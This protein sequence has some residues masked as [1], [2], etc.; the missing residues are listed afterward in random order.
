MT[1]LPGGIAAPQLWVANAGG[2]NR[3]G[4][5]CSD[6]EECGDFSGRTKPRFDPSKLK[7]QSLRNLWYL[8]RYWNY[9]IMPEFAIALFPPQLAL[10]LL[11]F[12]AQRFEQLFLLLTFHF[13][14][15]EILLLDFDHGPITL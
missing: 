8:L 5:W 10:Q 11:H 2:A 12:L 15:R 6:C 14:L 9:E 1:T 3:E 13:T 7:R 4:D